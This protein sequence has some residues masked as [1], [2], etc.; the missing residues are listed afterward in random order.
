[1]I[2]ARS[3]P[4]SSRK[5]ASERLGVPRA[6]LEDVADLD[7]GREL[8]R[9]AAVRAGVVFGRLAQIGEPRLE[10]APRLDA[11]QMPAVAVGAGD[12]LP[13]AQGLVGDDPRP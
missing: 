6:E 5:R 10:V 11:A 1:M 3:F 12:E 9:A 2:S 13:V 4:S 7:R 8:Q